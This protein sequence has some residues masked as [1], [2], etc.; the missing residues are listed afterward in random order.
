MAGEPSFGR[1]KEEPGQLIQSVQRAFRIVE[2][3]G[4]RTGGMTAKQI[5]R[6]CDLRLPTAY[7][8]LRTLQYEGYLCKDDDGKFSLGLEVSDRYR[9]L[10]SAIR[11]PINADDLMRRMSSET[12]YSYFIGRMVDERVAITA[13]NEG[14]R[15]PRVED[16]IVGFDEGAHATAL[17]KA[18]LAGMEAEQRE[19]YLKETGMRRY[20][21]RTLTELGQIEYDL[22]SLE[23]QGV[24][25][26]IGQFRNGVGCAAVLVR[27]KQDRSESVALAAVMPATDLRPYGNVI[28]Q[29]LRRA[30]VEMQPLL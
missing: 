29:R 28:K 18:L 17:G 26:E 5:A 22:A 27:G 21:P 16:L 6:E 20:T 25:T 2:A 11:G 14:G 10:T 7:H 15:S 19:R 23:R 9:E 4:K 13:V 3:V 24:Y 30:A 1:P 12:G 8:L